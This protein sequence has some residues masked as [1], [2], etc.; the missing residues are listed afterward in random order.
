MSASVNTHKQYS[1]G[2]N[3]KQMNYSEILLTLIIYTN[4][5]Y[6][7]MSTYHIFHNQL[8]GN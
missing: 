1:N 5:R 3:S 6:M 8:I 2:E 4:R 7:L